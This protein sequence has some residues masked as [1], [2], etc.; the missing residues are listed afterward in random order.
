MD[1][2]VTLCFSNTNPLMLPKMTATIELEAT[3]YD[4][5]AKFLLW[6]IIDTYVIIKWTILHIERHVKTPEYNLTWPV[7]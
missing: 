6:N 4:N 1:I 3:L 7:S 5:K 2:M